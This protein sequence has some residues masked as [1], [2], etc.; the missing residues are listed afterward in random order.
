[1]PFLVDP[2][3][4]STD[5]A[6]LLTTAVNTNIV[7]D[8]ASA[9][10]TP[11]ALGYDNEFT[12]G[13]AVLSH[14]EDDFT[15]PVVYHPT[16]IHPA[17]PTGLALTGDVLSWD[18]ATP[19][20][21]TSNGKPANEVGFNVQRA[22]IANG[23]IGAYSTLGV[24]PAN[25]TNYTDETYAATADYAYRVAAWNSAGTTTSKPYITMVAPAAPALS[26]V[27]AAG[28]EMLSWPAV[29]DTTAYLISV[30]GG[31]PVAVAPHT[32]T[33]N[34]AIVINATQTYT[35][36]A[37][38]GGSSNFTVKAQKTVLGTTVSSAPSN[39]VSV[40][41]APLQGQRR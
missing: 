33:K 38:T 21:A 16:V 17:E 4:I 30:N 2:G 1:L 28:K 24:V 36:P 22:S 7:V 34:K 11:S 10:S 32:S 40:T 31:V 15:R 9:T 13:A 3:V 35:L 41:I 25:A 12:W 37:L 20:G 29:A 23:A 14:S 19:A 5:G 39:T 6:S 18:D 26:F 8:N 27:S